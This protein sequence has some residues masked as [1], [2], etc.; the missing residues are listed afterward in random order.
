MMKYSILLVLALAILLSVCAKDNTMEVLDSAYMDINNGDYK[1]AIEAL[2]KLLPKEANNQELNYF[3]GQAYRG[4]LF[5]DGSEINE[6][7]PQLAEK[8]SNY[9][10]KVI[11]INPKYAGRRFVVGPYTKIQSIWG[12][13][14]TTHVDNGDIDAA[15]AAFVRGKS[16]GAFY[17]AIMEYNR[18]VMASCDKDAILFTNGDNDTYPPW[19][20]QLV[21]EYRK[22]ITIVNLSLLNVGWYIKQ[23]KNDYPYGTNTLEITMTDD[24]IDNLKAMKWEE[25]VVKIPVEP[26]PEN[27][28]GRFEWTV[29]PTIEGKGLRVQDQMVMEIIRANAWNR[30]VYFAS[31]VY[32]VNKIGLDDYLSLEGL[33]FRLKPYEQ[34]VSIDQ[35]RKNLMNVYQYDGVKDKHVQYMDEIQSLYKNY[36]AGFFELATH[37]SEAGENEKLKNVLTFMKE[38]LPAVLLPYTN[39]LMKDAVMKLQEKVEM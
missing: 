6:V 9:F 34:A 26:D 1:K 5:P 16:E 30:P 21:E 29:K 7:D 27:A 31:T 35:M 4:L 11:E 39:E 18:N 19:Y 12:S 24:E 25:R 37:Y 36:R 3:L 28:E 2:E 10:S 8:A 32:N 17:P 20:M 22:D 14:A 13:V 33:V 23:L 38:K 15:I